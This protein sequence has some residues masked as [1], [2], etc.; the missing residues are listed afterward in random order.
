MP[1]KKNSSH[2]IAALGQGGLGLP[3]KDYYLSEDTDR[4][5][6]REKYRA[7]VAAMLTAATGLWQ[8]EQMVVDRAITGARMLKLNFHCLPMLGCNQWDHM[9]PIWAF[10]KTVQD[11]CV[12]ELEFIPCVLDW[13]ALVEF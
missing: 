9:K 6:I 8:Y 12:T 11:F 1:D 2:S 3:D 5:E 10:M 4:V 7:H 13:Q